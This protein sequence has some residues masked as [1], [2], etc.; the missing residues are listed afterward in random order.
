MLATL[1]EFQV[2]CWPTRWP[3]IML[4]LG[5]LNTLGLMVGVKSTLRYRLSDANEI[6]REGMESVPAELL[7]KRLSNPGLKQADDPGFPLT[8]IIEQTAEVF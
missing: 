8:T 3:G 5:T 7:Q 4:G 2:D 6:P 1:S